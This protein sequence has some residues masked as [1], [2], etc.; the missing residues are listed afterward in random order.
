MKIKWIKMKNFKGYDEKKIVFDPG[1]VVY[2][3]SGKNGVGKTSLQQAIRF[4]I[5]GDAPDNIIKRGELEAT[6]TCELEDGTT[7]ERTKS[8][9]KATKTTQKLNGKAVTGT[10]LNDYINGMVGALPGALKT[11]LDPNLLENMKPEQLSDF[12]IKAVGQDIPIENILTYTGT[13][14]SEVLSTLKSYLGGK[15]EVSI[16]DIENAYKAIFDERGVYKKSVEK[17]KVQIES[18][19]FETPSETLENVNRRIE[20]IVKE[21]GALES[22]KLAVKTYERALEGKKK[23]DEFIKNLEAEIAKNTAKAPVKSVI[24]AISKEKAEVNNQIININAVIKTMQDTIKTFKET[25]ERLSSAFCPLSESITCN[26]VKEREKLKEEFEEQIVAQNEGI[27]IQKKLLADANNKIAELNKKEAEY[28]AN[29]TEYQKK[30]VLI[31]QLDDAKKSIVTLPTKPK[32][33]EADTEE[34]EERKKALETLKTKIVKCNERD[35]NKMAL[36]KNMRK[37]D[38]LDKLVKLLAPKG[39]VMFNILDYFK[40]EFEDLL[41]DRANALKSD[42]NIKLN[43]ESGVKIECETSAGAGYVPYESLSSGEKAYV[44]FLFIDLFANAITQ[45]NIML[46]DDLDKLDS[47]AFDSLVELL[48]SKEITDMYDHI[49]IASVNH[50]DSVNSLSKHTD[51]EM[52]IV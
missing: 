49:F 8:L 43:L 11:A 2:A 5:T 25:I 42:F 39:V 29:A 1:K 6:V 50:E 20:S 27:E 40:N 46:L 32:P 33:V 26:S 4:I 16:S 38:I 28:N 23:Q 13:T 10:V 52:N 44:I 31:K 17:L 3:M 14:D 9:T 51:I 37:Y 24:E 15:K 35:N 19:P 7:I 36:E 48:T 12:L 45:V 18:V 22:A 41:N 30:L 47:G 21:E 34:L